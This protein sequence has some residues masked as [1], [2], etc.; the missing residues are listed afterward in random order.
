MQLRQD[1]NGMEE[2]GPIILNKESNMKH[3]TLLLVGLAILV[4]LGSIFSCYKLPGF[5]NDTVTFPQNLSQFG[6]YPGAP[7]SLAHPDNYK[8]YE[9]ATA[10]FSDYAEK[11]RLI[12]VPPGKKLIP[13]SDELPDFPDSTIIVKTFFYYHNKSDTSLGK[14]II[15]TRLL[16]RRRGKWNAATYAWNQQQ[17]DAVLIDSGADLP[18]N[19]IDERGTPRV[20]TYH[21]PSRTEC[22]MCHKDEQELTPIGPKMRNMNVDVYRNGATINQLRFL[23]QEAL[24][25]DLDPSAYATLPDWKNSRYSLSQRARAYLDVNCGHCH[26]PEGLASHT[27]LRLSYN[28]SMDETNI[29]AKKRVIE[30]L[31]ESGGMPLIGTTLVD[32]DALTLIRNYLTSIR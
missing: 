8:P 7:G 21:I 2:S 10:L 18:I 24:F 20:I 16:I 9:L 27:S 22:G 4:S 17:T 1:D 28:L 13:M 19:W 32:Q 12:Y 14:R 23:Q 15:E 30:K 5:V 26:R 6:I 11:Q 3:I 29:P 25:D 31:M